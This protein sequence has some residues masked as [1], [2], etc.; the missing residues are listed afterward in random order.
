[1]GNRENVKGKGKRE[2]GKTVK[3]T[4]TRKCGKRK[5]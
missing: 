3:G 2:K 5:I 1:M 4:V